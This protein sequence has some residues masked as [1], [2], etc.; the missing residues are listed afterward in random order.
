M[1]NLAAL[2]AAA[3]A[4]AGP[5]SAETA[6]TA[7]SDGTRVYAETYFG[8]LGPEAPLVAMFHQARSNGRGE[9]APLAAWLNALGYRAI[10]FDQR[11]GGSLYGAE[12]RTAKEAKG[13]KGFCDA[14]PDIEAG[15]AFAHERAA[16]APLVVW[17]SS[18]SAS[19]VWRAAAEHADKIDAL[20]A[21]STATGGALDRCGAKAHLPRLAAAPVPA[22][23]LWPRSESGQAAK[24][25]ALLEAAGAQTLIVENGVHGSS[26]LVDDRS[27]GDK[28]AAR[29]AV[30][31]WLDGHLGGKD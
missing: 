10:A 28:S 4:L 15:V 26:T 2:L 11:S 30:A 16:G 20:V 19:L 22:L 18:Y 14:W 8:A 21:A 25:E 13:A 12:N 6:T 5:A 7:A 23:A 9:Y 31:A 17:G 27:G 29:E 3:F 24:L 1:R